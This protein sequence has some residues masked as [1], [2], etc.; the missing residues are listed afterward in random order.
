[1]A[2]RKI[3]VIGAGIMG[4]GIAADMANHGF[5][6]TL[7][8]IDRDRAEAG[9][10]SQRRQGAFTDSES[11]SRIALGSIDDDLAGIASAD[12]IIEAAAETLAVK[13]AI[14][15]AVE[16]VRKPGSIV[17][18]NT[19][20]I[21]LAELVAGQPP[22]FAA[23]FLITHFFNPPR[24]M[25]LLELVAGPQ[26]RR[27]AVTAIRDLG[28]Q[29]LSK[30]VIEARDTPGFVANRIGNFWM[31]AAIEGAL[32]LHLDVEAADAAISRPFGAPVGAFAL[33]DLVG[34]DLASSVWRSLQAALPAQDP[35]QAFD[36]EPPLLA[37]MIA[38]GRT[39]RKAGAGFTRRRDDGSFET[40]DLVSSAYRPQRAVAP[41]TGNIAD[42]VRSATPDG[43]YAARVWGRTLA[44]ARSLVPETIASETLADQAMRHGY[45]WRQGPFEL[46]HRLGTDWL[47][48]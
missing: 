41:W 9:I 34:I 45:G 6:V 33:L 30:I 22:A 44:Y 8:D 24:T 38:D 1:M 42:L 28:E 21:L 31:A 15:A 40:L 20:T 16:P 2:F 27:D 36:P 18:S 12:W 7:L 13:Q 37:R 32:A 10:A 29:H 23:D 5:T 14:F 4:S 39:G 47:P 48:N 46:L 43:R 11:P 17:S 35:I 3:A 25:R 19:S 26:T